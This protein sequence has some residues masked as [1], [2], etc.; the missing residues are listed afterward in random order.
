MTEKIKVSVIVPVF[1]AEIYLASCLD[2]ILTQQYEKLEIICI[3]DA[4]TDGSLRILTSYQ[5]QDP[6]IIVIRQPFNQGQS[7]ARNKGLEYANGKY[8]L[9]V[10]ADD[11]IA[12][13]LIETSVK[14]AEEHN[15]DFLNYSYDI[16]TNEEG[17]DWKIK[18]D[19]EL[20]NFV[21]RVMNGREFLVTRENLQGAPW[22]PWASLFNRLFLERN[23]LAFYNGII[24]EDVLF[25]FKSCMLAERV[26][27]ISHKL[28]LYRKVPDS[29]TTS[30]RKNRGKSVFIVISEIYADWLRGHYSDE[31]NQAIG[32]LLQ[33]MWNV[34]N[35]AQLS[36]EK[37]YEK[38]SISPAADFMYRMVNGMLPPSLA[39]LDYRDIEYLKQH[40]RFILFGCGSVAAEIVCQLERNGLRPSYIMVTQHKGNPPTFAGIGVST[41]DELGYI[42]DT[43]VVVACSKRLCKEVKEMLY[44]IGY[45]VLIFAKSVKNFSSSE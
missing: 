20:R 26:M 25:Y 8:I 24:H 19:S 42:E 40:P 44:G 35:R 36:G 23:K 45:E 3:D 38:V 1:N 31:V 39:S 10:D 33:S 12:P 41:A 30:W 11:I 14:Y 43:P 21:S 22:A 28:Y 15:L 7:S 4:S 5:S 34:Y 16:I 27:Y 37:E 32:A 6:R 2:S 17:W 29:T 13:D 9:F 18:S